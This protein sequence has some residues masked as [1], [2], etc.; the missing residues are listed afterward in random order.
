MIRFTNPDYSN[1]IIIPA[2]SRVSL[3]KR[4]RRFPIKNQTTKYTITMT[5]TLTRANLSTTVPTRVNPAMKALTNLVTISIL[6]RKKGKRR[7]TGVIIIKKRKKRRKNMNSHLI[8]GQTIRNTAKRQRLTPRVMRKRITENQN[9]MMIMVQNQNPN[10]NQ[11]VRIPGHLQIIKVLKGLSGNTRKA[12]V[13]TKSIQC[14]N[15][16]IKSRSFT[17]NWMKAKIPN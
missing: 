16:S 10:P 9:S 13:H 1:L 6:R 15:M 8:L 7:I 2:K 12:T 14:T 4:I 3:A 11:L 5:T 17:T